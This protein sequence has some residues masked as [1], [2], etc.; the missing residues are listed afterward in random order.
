LEG[1]LLKNAGAKYSDW[2]NVGDYFQRANGQKIFCRHL[3]GQGKD[4]LFLHGFPTSSF[5]WAD[6]F[7]RLQGLASLTTFDFLGFGASDK[8]INHRYNY[9]EQSDIAAEIAGK[10]QIRSCILVAHDY[11]VTVAQELLKRQTAGELKFNIEKVIFLNGGIYHRLHRPSIVQQ[12]LLMPVI[13]A[14]VARS[15]TLAMFEK[16]LGKI[17]TGKFKLSKNEASELWQ[18]VA[19]N[20]GQNISHKLLHYIA[21]R[22]ENGDVWE[23]AM[24]N[25]EVPYVLVWGMLDPISGKHMLDYAKTRL[26]AAQIIELPDVAHYPQIEDPDS[27][28][29]AILKAV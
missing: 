13:G 16:A 11:G 24:E 12:I 10:Y 25:S 1:H 18:G 27:V 22:K 9:Q 28:A 26:S 17:F 29:Q 20:G 3:E 6:V 5:D 21:E 4:I 7:D 2:L 8:P 15:M 19:R 14:M 23:G